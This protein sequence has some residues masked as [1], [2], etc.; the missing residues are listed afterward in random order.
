L[1]LPNVEIEPTATISAWNRVGL[2]IRP[3]ELILRVMAECSR[4]FGRNE[5]FLTQ[6]ELVRI[7]IP[8]AGVYAPIG[9]HAVVLRAFRD[10]LTTLPGWPNVIPAA[11]DGRMAREFLIFLDHYGF[12]ASEGRGANLR[13]RLILSDDEVASLVAATPATVAA[14]LTTVRADGSAEPAERRRVLAEVT[15]RPGQVAFRRAVVVAYAGRCLLTGESF[16]P[17]LQAAHIRPVKNDGPDHVSNGLLLRADLH[18]LYDAGHI[19]IDATGALRA[20]AA[21]SAAAGSL[22]TAL[23]AVVAWPASVSSSFVDWRERY[24]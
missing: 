1:I 23:P 6:E 12:C 5:A 21:L 4:R 13:S 14:A 7:V 9:R 15:V 17:A 16:P 22:Y 10:G 19:R 11:N 24:T 18:L 2:R 20:S 8:L 3:L